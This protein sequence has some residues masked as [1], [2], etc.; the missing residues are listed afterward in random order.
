MDTYDDENYDD[1]FDEEKLASNFNT[2]LWAKLFAYAR[3]HP[4][5]LKWLGTFA[6]I[7]A[8]MEVAYP[9]LTNS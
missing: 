4:S 1:G 9:L 2:A 7:T 3:R 8:L 5:D 6:V